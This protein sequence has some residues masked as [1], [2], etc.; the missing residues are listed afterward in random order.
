MKYLILTLTL[1]LTAFLQGNFAIAEVKNTNDAFYWDK[2]AYPQGWE[3]T[4]KPISM[5]YGLPGYHRMG[6]LPSYRF[7]LD[8]IGGDLNDIPNMDDRNTDYRKIMSGMHFHKGPRLGFDGISITFYIYEFETQGK[9]D[10]F[11]K[12]IR[13]LT[14]DVTGPQN[15]R[16]SKKMM[17]FKT[18]LAR[19]SKRIGTSRYQNCHNCPTSGA[20]S[21]DFIS[22]VRLGSM[23]FGDQ[24][25]VLPSIRSI[26]SGISSTYECKNNWLKLKSINGVGGLGEY[27]NHSLYFVSRANWL[28]VPWVSLSTDYGPQTV[29][30]DCF[31]SWKAL[32]LPPETKI[33]AV[34]K[35]AYEKM[36]HHAGFPANLPPQGQAGKP[37]PGILHYIDK[38]CE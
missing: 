17:D 25:L 28:L 12:L 27:W 3:I 29:N 34:I 23:P 18:T 21:Y 7:Y 5:L 38:E 35:E 16:N 6:D 15:L 36:S 24:S 9:L 4:Q 11:F 14:V 37:E 13:N 33:L 20:I 22:Q 2:H 31:L 8:F 19:E 1:I 32:K 10:S 26:S 30:T